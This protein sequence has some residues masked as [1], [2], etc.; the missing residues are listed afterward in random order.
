MCGMY[1]ALNQRRVQKAPD[2]HFECDG[3]WG[4]VFVETEGLKREEKEK[5]SKKRSRD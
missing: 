5:D 1:F 4:T 3:A 2:A